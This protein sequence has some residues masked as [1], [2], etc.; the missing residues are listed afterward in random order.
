VKGYKLMFDT[1]QPFAYPDNLFTRNLFERDA[2]M[3]IKRALARYGSDIVIANTPPL[4]SMSSMLH[5]MPPGSTAM[6]LGIGQRGGAVG[7]DLAIPTSMVLDPFATALHRR[8]GRARRYAE[9]FRAKSTKANWKSNW[10][11]VLILC[12]KNDYCP[13]PLAPDDAMEVVAEL[14]DLGFAFGSIRNVANAI[15]NAHVLNGFP[16]PTDTADFRQIMDGI[17]RTIGPARRSA[18]SPFCSRTSRTRSRLL[19]KI[20]SSTMRCSKRSF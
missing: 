11:L 10:R 2:A 6:P 18:R 5:D 19:R 9:N 20:R 12:A 15:R 8:S 4:T 7:N 13:Y 17:A 3:Y 14:A 16:S 1:A